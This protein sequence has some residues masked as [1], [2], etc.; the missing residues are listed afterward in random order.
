MPIYLDAKSTAAVQL[1]GALLRGGGVPDSLF[2]LALEKIGLDRVN[3]VV[4]QVG[5]YCLVSMTLSAFDVPA[6]S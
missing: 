3:R 6:S 4:F 5:L 2:R 1:T